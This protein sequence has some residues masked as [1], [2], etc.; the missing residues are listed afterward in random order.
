VFWK[1]SKKG[2][3]K[4]ETG[5]AHGSTDPEKKLNSKM[6]RCPAKILNFQPAGGGV[7]KRGA[8]KENGVLDVA[9]LRQKSYKDLRGQEQNFGVNGVED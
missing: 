6:V 5:S 4:K 9:K 8:G 2:E 3:E 7:C 1:K